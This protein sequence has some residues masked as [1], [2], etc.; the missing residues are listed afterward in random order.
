MSMQSQVFDLSKKHLSKKQSLGNFQHAAKQHLEDFK[1]AYQEVLDLYREI[2]IA[3][4]LLPSDCDQLM[5]K[6]ENLQKSVE[7]FNHLLSKMQYLPDQVIP[8]RYSL[9]FSLTFLEETSSRLLPSLW[10]FRRICLDPSRETDRLQRQVLEKYEK[11]L[12]IGGKIELSCRV[13]LREDQ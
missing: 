4:Y 5:D 8:T 9:M 6:I 11:V 10:D 7:A 12:Q 1:I 2:S 3:A 13:F